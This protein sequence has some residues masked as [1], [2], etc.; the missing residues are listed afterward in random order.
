M[1][2]PSFRSKINVLYSDIAK[3]AT[4]GGQTKIK[5]I[6]LLMVLVVSL[7]GYLLS[8]KYLNRALF[9]NSHRNSRLHKSRGTSL[10]ALSAV[11]A[12]GQCFNPSNTVLTRWSA[13]NLAAETDGL[14]A[15]HIRRFLRTS[16]KG[17]PCALVIK[18][19]LV[20]A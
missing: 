17:I 3:R 11:K 9:W 16:Q 20:R 7:K 18:V 8:V 4:L 5:Y 14:L 19:D 13:S 2:F 15:K 12:T 6:R 1:F 10:K